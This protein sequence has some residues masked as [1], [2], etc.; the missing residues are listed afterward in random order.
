MV[1]ADLRAPPTA[2]DAEDEDDDED[3]EDD[4][5][6]EE[7]AAAAER[8][9]AGAVD[10]RAEDAGARAEGAADD[11]ADEDADDAASLAAT[12]SSITRSK[13]V[14]HTMA[15]SSHPPDAKKS[16]AGEKRAHSVDDW[17]P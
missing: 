2:A 4:E 16:P 8:P 10:G 12:A 14:F 11:D 7:E 9:E 17:W 1:S 13:F 3:D 5:E 15:S 6:E